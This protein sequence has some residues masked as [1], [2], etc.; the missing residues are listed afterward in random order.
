MP[1]RVVL[2]RL[3]REE[4]DAVRRLA[5]SRTEPAAVVQRSRVIRALL[6][7][8]ALSA[9]AAARRAG[10]IR[11][12]SGPVWVRRFN[13]GGVTAL[14]DA[15]RS[16][17]PPTHTPE[18]RSQLV[19]LAVQKPRSLGHEFALWTLER[20][21]RAFEAAHHVHLSDSTIWEWLRDEGLVWKRQQTWFHE[22]HRHDPQF[23]EKRGPSSRRTSRRPSGAGSSASTSSARSR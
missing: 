16:G 9:G 13:A 4:V 15:P 8:P 3:S 17:R 23:A 14:R 11:E 18:V 10:F 20:L 19:A 2:R 6:E 1:A 22:P 12:D 21:Q 7:E 5:A